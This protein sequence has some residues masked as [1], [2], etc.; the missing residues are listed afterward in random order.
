[1]PQSYPTNVAIRAAHAERPLPET[2]AE[3]CRYS[4]YADSGAKGGKEK[5]VGKGSGTGLVRRSAVLIRGLALLE[6]SLFSVV[7]CQCKRGL[8]IG[9]RP[10]R[11]HRRSL[12]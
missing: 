7:A 1:M 5:G 2:G 9:V 11:D 4:A 12:H 6:T 10:N 3:A 8:Q